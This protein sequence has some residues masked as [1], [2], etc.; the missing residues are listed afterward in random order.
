MVESEAQVIDG[1][2]HGAFETDEYV[3]VD[4]TM[5]RICAPTD[6]LGNKRMKSFI[7]WTKSSP[8]D[9]TPTWDKVVSS[10]PLFFT[11]VY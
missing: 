9:N 7:L 1:L 8:T 10:S 5:N 4:A 2:E 6:N 3:R 11:D